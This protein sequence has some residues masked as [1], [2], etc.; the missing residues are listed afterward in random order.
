MRAVRRTPSKQRRAGREAGTDVVAMEAAELFHRFGSSPEGLPHEEARRRP[1]RYGP[2]EL[3]APH[4]PHPARL[5]LAQVTHTLALLLW[6]GAG[7]AFLAGLPQLGWA[8]LAIV[9]VNA[10][11]SFWQEYRASRLVQALHRQLPAAV[12]VRRDGLEQRI[13]ASALVPG[14]VLILQ[15]GDRVA[16]DARLLRAA[17]LRLDYS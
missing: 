16:A 4:P 3:P 2:N 8:I 1:A 9:L 11:F 5:F 13:L 7:L 10:A 6:G 14:D 17:D 15:R 12:R